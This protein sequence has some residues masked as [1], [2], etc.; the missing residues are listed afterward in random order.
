M[1]KNV[2]V[3]FRPSKIKCTNSYTEIEFLKKN[4]LSD[5]WV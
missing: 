5:N 3:N 2:L 1:K 4:Q